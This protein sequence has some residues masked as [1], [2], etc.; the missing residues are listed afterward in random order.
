MAQHLD[1][2]DLIAVHGDLHLHF[3]ADLADAG[4]N[5]LV[6]R[7]RF[8]HGSRRFHR[9]GFLVAV[10]HVQQGDGLD[11]HLGRNSRAAG[12]ALRIG[13]LV[14]G[15]G[16]IGAYGIHAV[17]GMRHGGDGLEFGLIGREFM[18]AIPVKQLVAHFVCVLGFADQ[19]DKGERAGQ[20]AAQRAR[21]VAAGHQAEGLAGDHLV[22]RNAGHFA[23]DIHDA[24]KAAAAAA[25]IL[26]EHLV[27]MIQQGI[28]IHGHVL[29]GPYGRGLL[30]RNG[31]GQR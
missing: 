28:L 13:H 27:A 3:A 31:A 23:E 16:H 18:L 24:A 1:L 20:G 10:Q 4:A 29:P 19:A 11:S 25:A 6:G 14:P 26:V 12:L 17:D 22:V 8:F 15:G 9:L 7:Q 5:V 30:L 2:G 21:A